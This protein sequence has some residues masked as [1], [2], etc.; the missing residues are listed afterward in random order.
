MAPNQYTG[1]HTDR[2]FV[3]FPDGS[4]RILTAW[5]PLGDVSTE[6]GSLLIANH[7][8]EYQNCELL[9]NYNRQVLGAD[10]T[11]SGWISHS[12][13]DLQELLAQTERICLSWSTVDFNAGDVCIIGMDSLHQTL[14][15]QLNFP[16]LSADTRWQPSE[17]PIGSIFKSC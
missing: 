15:N 14:C 17:D 4:Q 10:G 11:H 13:K 8:I 9:K 7:V 6:N 3:M 5:V 2:K 12:A 1:V 16:R